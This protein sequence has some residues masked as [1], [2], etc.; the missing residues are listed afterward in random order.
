MKSFLFFFALFL[1]AAVKGQFVVEGQTQHEQEAEKA[2]EEKPFINLQKEFEFN[3]NLE[4]ALADKFAEIDAQ[5]ALDSLFNI[6]GVATTPLGHIAAFFADLVYPVTVLSLTVFGFYIVVQIM[7]QF[8][9][10]VFSFKW[11]FLTAFADGLN[12]VGSAVINKFLV[13]E[14]GQENPE[15]A[16]RTQRQL[17][18]LAAKV[19]NAI[20]RYSGQ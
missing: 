9:G 3:A 2:Q 19:Y 6:T 20:E 5:A 10:V 13:V 11:D 7:A 8:F 16:Q 4:S 12:A 18:E 15:A 17:L 1:L 14:E